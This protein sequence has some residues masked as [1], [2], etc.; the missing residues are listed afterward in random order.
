[1]TLEL[2]KAETNH[3]LQLV[4]LNGTYQASVQWLLRERTKT[5]YIGALS[6]F[7]PAN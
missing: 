3:I 5:W 6:G 4:T 1:M 7:S 2:R